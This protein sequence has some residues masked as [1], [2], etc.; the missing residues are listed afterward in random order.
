MSLSNRLREEHRGYFT[1][2][3]RVLQTYELARSVA[4]AFLGGTGAP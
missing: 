1:A 4:C 2:K 3:G